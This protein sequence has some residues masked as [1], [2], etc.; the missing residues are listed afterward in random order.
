MYAGSVRTAVSGWARRIKKKARADSALPLAGPDGQCAGAGGTYMDQHA[1]GRADG[2]VGLCEGR[3]VGGLVHGTAHERG[4]PRAWWMSRGWLGVHADVVLA[5]GSKREVVRCPRPRSGGARTW[6]WGGQRGRGVGVH[7]EVVRWP[8]VQRC[9]RGGWWVGCTVWG[10]DIG[11]VRARQTAWWGA[12]YQRGISNVV[13]EEYI[14]KCTKGQACAS[15]HVRHILQSQ[16]R[17]MGEPEVRVMGGMAV[18]MNEEVR[19]R[20]GLTAKIAIPT[21]PRLGIFSG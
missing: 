15:H 12:M 4:A 8:R 13:A 17:R 11:P 21:L 1:Y 2:Q 5:R 6:A 14:S 9:K 16:R 20:R 19:K 18:G 3:W 7:V 10:A